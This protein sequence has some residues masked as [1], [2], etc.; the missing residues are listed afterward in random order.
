MKTKLPTSWS[1]T[2]AYDP[3]E[4][5][6]VELPTVSFS[7]S[8]TVGWFGR[9]RGI[10]N[11]GPESGMSETGVIKGRIYDNNV[12]FTK[13]MPIETLMN[14]DGSTYRTKK[15][16]PPIKYF[17]S[18]DLAANVITGKWTIRVS[19]FTIYGFAHVECTGTW[20]ATPT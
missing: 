9:L 17:G 16:H 1:G 15:R 4:G 3:I 20:S 18:Y 19:P 12:H 13:Y 11:D 10:V 7:M 2:Y 8:W 6:E 5:M 14:P